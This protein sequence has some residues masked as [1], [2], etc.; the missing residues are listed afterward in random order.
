MMNVW[1]DGVE[2]R[3]DS[4][5]P[6]RNAQTARG[7]P[8]APADMSV[9]PSCFSR[10]CLIITCPSGVPGAVKNFFWRGLRGPGRGN[11]MWRLATIASAKT[12]NAAFGKRRF[13]PSQQLRTDAARLCVPGRGIERQRAS[14]RMFSTSF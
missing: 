1:D 9:W 14:L 8:F 3:V 2:S 5:S 13:P 10:H 7:S 6:P 12:L 11:Q 4:G